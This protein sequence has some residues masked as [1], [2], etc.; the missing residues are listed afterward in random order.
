MNPQKFESDTRYATEMAKR[1]PGR[2]DYWWPYQLGLKRACFGADVVDDAKHAEQLKHQ[3]YRDGLARGEIS[4]Q[5]GRPSVGDAMLPNIT[6]PGE[7]KTALQAHADTHGMTLA[8]TRRD[9]YRWLVER[10]S[11]PETEAIRNVCDAL[12]ERTNAELYA[13]RE[14]QLEKEY[15][16]YKY[17]ANASLE[18]NMYVFFDRLQLYAW[19]CERW[20][21][22]HNG[23][24][25]V[26]EHVRDKFLMPKIRLFCATMDSDP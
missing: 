22:H 25:C 14:D 4:S 2:A 6:L 11:V 13:M 10:A 7:L 8:E 18:C 19:F 5:I 24:V 17:D 20:W 12:V 9:A 16:H 23:G 26:V 3:G 15:W 1:E 21:E